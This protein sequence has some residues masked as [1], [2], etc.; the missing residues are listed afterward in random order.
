VSSR[1]GDENMAKVMITPRPLLCATPAVLVGA[2]VDGKPNFMTVAWCGV[3]NSNPPMVTVSIQP[4]RY[5]FRGIITAR[6]FSLNVPSSD[7]VKEVDYCGISSGTKVDK[8]S[9]CGFKVFYG[10]LKAAPLI[11]QCPINLACK[12]EHIMELG[13]HH[14]VIGRVEETHVTDTCLNDGRP[15]F[16]QIKPFIYSATM[17]ANY[18]ACGE[19]LGRAFSVGRI[20][21]EK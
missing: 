19:I 11:E 9:V 21:T 17:P 13:T 16:G 4:H 8:V 7:Q 12:V 1:K 6:E 2:V 5:T 10:N 18:Y 14:L 15:D 20:L 3:A